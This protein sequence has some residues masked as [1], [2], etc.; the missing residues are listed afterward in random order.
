MHE[1]FSAGMP[2]KMTGNTAGM[3]TKLA[4]IPWNKNLIAKNPAEV[5]G[6]ICFSKPACLQLACE[7]NPER[8]PHR[9]FCQ[10]S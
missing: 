1:K 6:R 8:M 7:M 2:R 9:A 3:E 5:V 4:T 10:I